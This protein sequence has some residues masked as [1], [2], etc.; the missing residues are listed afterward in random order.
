VRRSGRRYGGMKA[1]LLPAALAF[2]VLAAGC[3]PGRRAPAA[4]A[5]SV[6][7][8]SVDTL[9]S[10]RVGAYGARY[11]A[12][13]VLDA[14]AAQGL[15]CEKAI[16]PV[17]I[18]LPAHAT[19]FT[20]LYPPRHGVRHNGIF[21]LAPER[22]TLA[23]RFR[24]AGYATAAVV[25]AVVL[26]KRYGLDQGFDRYDDRFAGEQANATGYL[27]RPAAE[28][29]AAALR[30]LA[31]E[32][33]PFFLFAHYYD[34]HAAYHPPAPFAERFAGAPY[35]GEIA[36]VD[37]A[38]GALLDGLRA[39]GRLARTIVVVTADHGESLGEHGE[40][41]HSYGLYDATLSVPLVF[42][43]PGVP[44]GRTLPGVVSLASVAPTVLALAGLPPLPET[45]GEDLRLRLAAPAEGSAYAETLAT[46][47]DHGWAP[48]H[49]LRTPL[50]HYVRAPRAELYDVKAD[51]RERENRLAS[52]PAAQ[53]AAL[54]GG[55]D[56]VLALALPL[57]RASVDD[58]TL[59]DLRALGY[60]LPEA[61]AEETGIDPKDGL[62][63]I[64]VDFAA[65]SAL[66]AGDVAKAEE[67]ARELLAASPRSAQAHLLLCDVARARG[68]LRTALTEAERAAQLVPEAASHA[69]LVGDLR[70]ETGDI[71][72]AVAAYRAA[73][74][75]DPG[76][77]EAIAGSMWA[78][79]LSE[80]PAEAEAAAQAARAARP[81]DP[82][83]AL[84]VGE[85]WDRMGRAELALAAY[86]D[87]IRLAPG[88]GR[89]EMGAAIQ[90]A[91]LGRDA[92]SDAHA[93]AA[94]AFASEP[95]ARNRLAIAFAARG[96]SARAEAMFRE[97]LA[98][99]P[100]HANT[101][102]NLARLLRSTSRA[103]EADALEAG[104]GTVVSP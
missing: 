46:Q 98:A 75:A 44:E 43:G 95:N 59:R 69:T 92:E 71:P 83:I 77:A 30:W 99:H 8:I 79:V 81:D 9:R 91:R 68:D 40:R 49:A 67:G 90:L 4:D 87:A 24:D 47:L 80:D 1:R 53:V 6:L 5:P 27:E 35:E 76:Y 17:P 55:I 100:D 7:L 60:A 101:R 29:T 26:E 37:A 82:A 50:V 65:R 51:P 104:A 58:A 73:L 56:A 14:L 34:P 88:N 42:A 13:P 94:G 93:A 78:A 64:A 70:I 85:A 33:G 97:L 72:G 63:L 19:L 48:L 2:A 31:E 103:A 41:T 74:G 66:A 23:E 84:R 21:R 102:R 52:A 61:A 15:R 28:V 54:E 16:S 36:S 25:G 45:D 3:S 96:A 86:E 10:D 39:S 57:R 38:I 20:G 62:R 12:T 22:I 32:K 18:T 89:A 11:G